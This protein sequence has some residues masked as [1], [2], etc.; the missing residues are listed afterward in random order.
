MG[1]GGG[2]KTDSICCCCLEYRS[3]TNCNAYLS[4]EWGLTGVCI[5]V[6]ASVCVCECVFI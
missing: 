6:G 2:E 4:G 1:G 3:F 5:S